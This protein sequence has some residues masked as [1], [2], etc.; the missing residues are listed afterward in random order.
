MESGEDDGSMS[1][2]ERAM[3]SAAW[4]GQVPGI[5]WLHDFVAPYIGNKLAITAR[6]GSLRQFAA[7]EVNNRRERGTDRKDILSKLFAVQKEKP[8]EMDDN[9]VLS[10]ASS[11]IFAGSDTTAISTRAIIY[12]LLKNP[13]KKKKLVD[14]IDHML[15][16]GTLSDPV[17]LDQADK[18]PYLQACMY[19]ALRLHPAVGMSLPRVVPPGGMEIDGTFVPAGVRIFH[20]FVSTASC[21]D[22][23]VALLVVLECPC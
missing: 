14:E 2:I 4:V 10:M 5:Y 8:A 21:L 16:E 15:A 3:R 6:N 22:D 9:A 17:T 7:R 13:E 18:M 23:S 19:E 20:T 11:N 1:A 12:Y